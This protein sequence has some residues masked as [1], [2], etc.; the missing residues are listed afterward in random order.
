MMEEGSEGMKLWAGKALSAVLIVLLIAVVFC[1]Y[2]VGAKSKTYVLDSAAE[3][4]EYTQPSGVSMEAL[5]AQADETS[6]RLMIHSRPEVDLRTGQCSLML[7]NPEENSRNAQVVILLDS[8][9]SQLYQ[10]EVLS[11]GTRV[12]YAELE[13]TLEPGEHVATAIFHILDS[14]TGERIGEVTAGITICVPSKNKE[15]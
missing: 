1:F 4:G 6:F 2:A 7:G 9:Q 11:P 14:E 8:D 10:S 5:Q 3:E 15:R 12:P 13:K